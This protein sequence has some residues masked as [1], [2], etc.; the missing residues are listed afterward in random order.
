[1]LDIVPERLP[2]VVLVP[3]VRTLKRRD[4]VADLLAEQI[5][6]V[7]GVRLNE[8]PALYDSGSRLGGVGRKTTGRATTAVPRVLSR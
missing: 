5:F 3:D 2:L 4:D 7:K 6:G 1:V 8:C